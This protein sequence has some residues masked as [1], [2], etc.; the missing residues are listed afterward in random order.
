MDW[1]AGSERLPDGFTLKKPDGI[2]THVA[3]CEAWTNPGGLELR[4]TLDGQ[5]LPITT[6]VQSADA[7][8]TLIKTWRAV[9]QKT[10]WR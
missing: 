8:R 5:G 1:T 9:L 3:V 7:M 10:G 2:Q 6:V 4:L